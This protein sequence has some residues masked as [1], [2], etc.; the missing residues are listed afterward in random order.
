MFTGS[1]ESVGVGSTSGSFGCF[2]G[3]MDGSGSADLFKDEL[4]VS[5]RASSPV[6]HK[7]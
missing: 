7:L 5:F 4:G 6:A 3:L 1:F 2:D